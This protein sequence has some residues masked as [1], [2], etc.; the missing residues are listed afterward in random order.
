MGDISW[1]S[2]VIV[3]IVILRFVMLVVLRGKNGVEFTVRMEGALPH[4]LG[5]R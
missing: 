5:Y 3:M 1:P 4:L 2:I